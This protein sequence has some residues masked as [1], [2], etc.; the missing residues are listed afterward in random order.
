MLYFIIYCFEEDT[1][2]LLLIQNI[3]AEK[4][5]EEGGQILAVSALKCTQI[6]L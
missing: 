3:K 5:N 4:S 2:V 6:Q 1:V